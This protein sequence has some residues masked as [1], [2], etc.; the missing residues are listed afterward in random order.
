[1][2]KK[3]DNVE[4]YEITEEFLLLV[5]KEVVSKQNPEKRKEIERA[6]IGEKINLIDS[7]GKEF[8]V[9][10][11]AG[12][13]EAVRYYNLIERGYSPEDIIAMA[14]DKDLLYN[15]DEKLRP[16]Q[17]TIEF[18]I[19]DIESR[20]IKKELLEKEKKEAFIKSGLTELV[21]QVVR[22][23]SMR[24]LDGNIFFSPNIP[25]KKLKNALNS[26]ANDAQEED[27]LVLID[28]TIWGSAKDGI[29]LTSTAIYANAVPSINIF[30]INDIKFIGGFDNALYINDKRFFQNN[31]P[32]RDSMRLFTDM[33]SEIFN[34]VHSSGKEKLNASVKAHADDIIN[35]N[36]PTLVGNYVAECLEQKYTEQTE[37]RNSS[38][39]PELKPI[40][41]L[42][43]S[44]E[45]QSVIQK[46]ELL[47]KKYP[48][49]DY[50]Y[51]WMGKAYIELQDC[52]QA[53]SILKEGLRK[54]K[55][56]AY[57]CVKLGEAEW[58]INKDAKEALKWWC[59]S[60]HCHESNPHDLDNTPYLYLGAIAGG[61][62]LKKE[63]DAFTER[64]YSIKQKSLSFDVMENIQKLF[65]YQK[66]SEMEVIIKE[67]CKLYFS[68]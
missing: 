42:G 32:T 7:E 56:K 33:L 66:T 38:N 27:A 1:M 4:T 52:K 21:K 26:Y 15:V 20:N 34:Q 16:T 22:D 30:S 18:A 35:G 50:L 24:I 2:K 46:S 6:M 55:S 58:K 41:S 3:S 45:Y 29:L 13:K 40:P 28:N 25:K 47:I 51:F 39:T 48:D 63:C 8:T 11:S 19:V 64:A 10:V 60:I 62:G 57:L 37:T 53:Q 31:L 68:D 43:N 59:Q 36:E 5:E 14:V 23:H 12:Y 17:T 9:T 54:A 49:L 65:V 44:G 61:F 67:M